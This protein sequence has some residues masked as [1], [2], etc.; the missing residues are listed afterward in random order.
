MLL[1][2]FITG[3]FMII[4]HKVGPIHSTDDTIIPMDAGLYG[5]R[6]FIQPFEATPFLVGGELE[7]GSVIS[8]ESRDG[9][10]RTLFLLICFKQG[11]SGWAKASEY[12][13]TGLA[14]I[15]NQTNATQY[16]IST[17]GEGYDDLRRGSSPGKTNL[18]FAKSTCHFVQFVDGAGKVSLRSRANAFVARKVWQ[19]TTGEHAIT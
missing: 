3:G 19:P 16:S 13:K 6:S 10:K 9:T 4:G 15:S 5:I 7:L 11:K 12:I 8:A 14:Y 18:V 17:F 1:E 2:L